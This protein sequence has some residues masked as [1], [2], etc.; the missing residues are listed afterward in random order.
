MHALAEIVK[1]VEK[2]GDTWLVVR[3]P[4]SRLKEEIE[5]K[6]IT[7]TEMRFDDGRHISNLQR[8]KAYATIRDIA[9]ELGYLPEEMKEI[10]KCNYMIETG[11][12]YFS[13]SDCSMGTARDFITFLMDFVLREG[14]PLSDS[15]IERADDV[16][17]Y[18][19]AC[20]KH[21]KCAVCGKDG[22]IHHVDTI[23]MGN[24][25][26]LVDDSGYRKICLCR[27]HHTIAHQRGMPSFEKMYHVYGIV[28]DDNPDGKS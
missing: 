11:E 3:L 1:S 21:K 20:I 15:G 17:K 14:I 10:M 26:R 4:K 22:E 5:N 2:D 28:I 18:L 27:T 12:P 24:D 8:K 19:Y 6:T 7:N 16:G 23:G 9:I 25:R 13:L